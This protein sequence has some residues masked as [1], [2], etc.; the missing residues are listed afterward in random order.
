MSYEASWYRLTVSVSKFSVSLLPRRPLAL[1][2]LSRQ[3]NTRAP[4]EGIMVQC[5]LKG[6]CKQTFED[7]MLRWLEEHPREALTQNNG[8]PDLER[9]YF[10]MVAAQLGC[11]TPSLEEVRQILYKA[12][13]RLSGK[14]QE[15]N[16]R[17]HAKRKVSEWAIHRMPLQYALLLFVTPTGERQEEGGR[18]QE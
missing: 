7:G 10:N 15:A 16:A 4:A 8:R 5:E 17:K 9:L 6:E 12:K 13:Y 14:E 2:S 11:R 3:N 1:G 18:R